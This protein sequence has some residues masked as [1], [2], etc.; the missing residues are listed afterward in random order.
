MFSFGT[1]RDPATTKNGGEAAERAINQ[2]RIIA[3]V[4]DATAMAGRVR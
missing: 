1:F 4:K 3:I 2:P